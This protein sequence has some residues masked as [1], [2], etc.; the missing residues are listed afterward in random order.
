MK[1]LCEA[2]VRVRVRPY[3][4]YQ[5]Q[6]LEGT[7]HFRIPV[8]QGIGVVRRPRIEPQVVHSAWRNDVRDAPELVALSRDLGVML[9]RGV[10]D[11]FA[12]REPDHGHTMAEIGPGEPQRTVDLPQIVGEPVH[13]LV[14]D[15]FYRKI[16]LYPISGWP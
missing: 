2:L 15:Q 5:A 7:A 1:T 16:N 14:T 12:A 9:D 11:Q 10:Q 6:L 13:S 3:Y 8:E 4:C